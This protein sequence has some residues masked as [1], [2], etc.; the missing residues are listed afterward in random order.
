M[1]EPRFLDLRNQPLDVRWP[2]R[3][4]QAIFA[5]MT[6]DRVDDLGS[7]TSE[8]IARP[9]D[10]RRCLLGPRSCRRSAWPVLVPELEAGD[11]VV[12]DNLCGSSPQWCAGSDRGLGVT[13]L[14]LPP[15][16]RILTRSRW[17]LPTLRGL[18]HLAASA[19]TLSPPSRPSCVP[20]PQEQSRTSG[21]HSKTLSTP[22]HRRNA[23]TISLLL[24]MT[25]SNRKTL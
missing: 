25:Q 24:D 3:R 14:Y 15:C 12:M 20:P 13:L 17:P 7:F 1:S 4:N 11:V 22:S 19:G 6:T 5:E 21:P 9:E 23:K 8:K 2:L 10:N 18:F 16:R